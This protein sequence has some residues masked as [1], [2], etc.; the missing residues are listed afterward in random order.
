ML[1]SFS[2]SSFTISSNSYSV[3]A[4]HL[5]TLPSC[6]LCLIAEVVGPHLSHHTIKILY[7]LAYVSDTLYIK[8]FRLQAIFTYDGALQS[9]PC[10]NHGL[11]LVPLQQI[12][13]LNKLFHNA[14]IVGTQ[15]IYSSSSSSCQVF[16]PC[17]HVSI[18]PLDGR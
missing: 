5:F 10:F 1:S 12:H 11:H 3:V 18:I 4:C 14:D 6:E 16:K 15:Q 2:L 8:V 7:I 9:N 13:C 17:I